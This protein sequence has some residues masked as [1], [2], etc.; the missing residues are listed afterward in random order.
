MRRNSF[1][2]RVIR[3]GTAQGS[4][5]VLIPGGVY[6]NTER[7]TQCS[8]VVDMVVFIGHTLDSMIPEIFS[9]LIDSLI[10]SIQTPRLGQ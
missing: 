9:S 1:I 4:G 2:E 10:P 6:R 8:G 3:G 7:G 5:G